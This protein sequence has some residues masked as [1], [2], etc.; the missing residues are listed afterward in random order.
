MLWKKFLFAVLLVIYASRLWP[1]TEPENEVPDSVTAAETTA[2][3]T[4]KK[5]SKQV[6][7]K[8]IRTIVIESANSIEYTKQKLNSEKNTGTESTDSKTDKTQPAES[9]E[10]TKTPKTNEAENKINADKNEMESITLVGNVAVSVT[11]ADSGITDTIKAD[12]IVY[13][14]ARNTLYAEGNVYYTRTTSGKISETFSGRAVLFNVNGMSGVFLD[15]IMTSKAQKAN[16]LDYVIHSDTIGHDESGVTAFKDA[17][18]TTGTDDEPLWSINASRIW[19]LPGNELSFVNGYYSIGIVPIFYL[20]FFYYPADEMIFHPSFGYKSREGYFVQTTTYIMGR[21]PLEKGDNKTTFSNFFMSDSLKEQ[22]RDGLFFQ[23]LSTDAKQ[24]SPCYLKIIADSYSSLGYLIGLDGNLQPLTKVFSTLNFNSYFAFSHTLYPVSPDKKFFTMYRPD[25]TAPFNKSNFFGTTL[26]FRYSSDFNA[27]ISKSPVSLTVNLPFVSDPFFKGEFL[28]R[29]ESMNWFKFMLNRDDEKKEKI[30]EQSSYNWL[31]K[32][33]ASPNTGKLSPFLKSFS[34]SPLSCKLDFYSRSNTM[35]SPEDKLYAPDRKFYYPQVLKPEAN[36]SLSGTIFSTSMLDKK[37][38]DDKSDKNDFAIDGIEN[39]FTEF[40]EK[41]KNEIQDSGDTPNN[42]AKP[43]TAA[44]QGEQGTAE[45][46][47]DGFIP[48]YSESDKNKKNE[49]V[50]S[51]NLGYDFRSNFLSE[52]LWDYQQWKQPADVNWNSFYSRYFKLNYDAK[53][54]SD[55]TVWNNFLKIT[56]DFKI[57]QN[58]QRNPYVKNEAKKN[59]LELNNYKA[60]TYQLTNSNSVAIFPIFFSPM[61]ND[62][63]VQWSISEIVARNKFTGTFD[64]PQYKTEK[65]KWN[66]E[67][68]KSHDMSATFAVN[69]HSYKQSL[70]VTAALPPLLSSYAMAVSSAHPFG[71]LTADT[72]IYEKEKAKKKWFWSPFNITASWKLPYN[73]STSQKYTYN[74]E[75][76]MSELFNFSF[77]WEYFSLNFLMQRDLKYSLNHTTG[78]QPEGTEKKFIPKSLDMSFSNAGQPFEFYF[79]KNRIKFSLGLDS[80]V[81]F[82]MQRITESYFTFSPKLNFSI[83]EF[84]TLKIGTTSRNDVIARYFQKALPLD[85]VIPGETNML[86]DLLYSFYFWDTDMRK[87]S[88]F[89]IKS[90]DI[91]LE[92]DLKDWVLNFTYSFLPQ[93]KYNN[94]THRNEYTFVPKIT[95]LV[96]WKPIGDIKVK[97]LTENKKFSVERGEIK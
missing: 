26:P 23:N 31:L 13:N 93:S 73:I 32:F 66:K 10:T 96:T 16:A 77:K 75:E 24:Q 76:K 87:Q 27:A 35:L 45:T 21:K 70:K 86:K 79:W 3:D 34:L 91:A 49:E 29:S 71:S 48:V 83:H 9:S 89:K 47:L 12:K 54:D 44:K 33:T 2:D 61:F 4:D 40:S 57:T 64:A 63:N 59:D 69:L 18:L 37:D 85:V 50:V 43:D 6:P 41:E 51:Y 58:Y 8:K 74:I 17:K 20:P 88:G 14:K 82:N 94:T 60:N 55:L 53:L 5:T 28:N 7:P 30:S 97:T 78:W 25:G 68:I 46:Y 11:E 95:F 38:K 92:H 80:T 90:I 84:L 67:F 42:A 62:T 52:S 22:K 81:S 56:N 19:L 15:G 36:I 39:P 65:T 1:Q 72:K